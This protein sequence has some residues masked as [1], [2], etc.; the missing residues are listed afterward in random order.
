MKFAPLA[1][2]KRRQMCTV[3]IFGCFIYFAIIW[4]KF[5]ST[6]FTSSKVLT[7]VVNSAE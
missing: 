4:I 6:Y 1:Y 2:Y 3:I 7:A 5:C